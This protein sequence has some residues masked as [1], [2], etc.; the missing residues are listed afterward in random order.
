VAHLRLNRGDG[1]RTDATGFVKVRTACAISLQNAVD[2]DAVDVHVGIEQGA[3]R[4]MKAAAP[5]RQPVSAAGLHRR[6]PALSTAEKKR[7]SDET[8]RHS[9]S[10]TEPVTHPCS[11][12]FL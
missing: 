11:R 4:W 8:I 5:M 12:P 6:K 2:H 3:K 9:G 10:L 7:C 1:F